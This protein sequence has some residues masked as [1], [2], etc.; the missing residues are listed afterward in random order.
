M[1][2]K[3]IYEN[4]KAKREPAETPARAFVKRIM[5]AAKVSE[6]TVRSWLVGSR[7]PDLLAKEAIAAELGMTVEELFPEQRR[8]DHDPYP[9]E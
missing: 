4:E 7:K 5:E 6:S 3:E 9:E 8:E 2:F 1:T